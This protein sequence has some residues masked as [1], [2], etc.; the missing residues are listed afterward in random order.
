MAW[1]N[2]P[3]EDYVTCLQTPSQC[4]LVTMWFTKSAKSGPFECIFDE[5][6]FKP[7]A[8]TIQWEF[9]DYSWNSYGIQ[10]KGSQD[11]TNFLRSAGITKGCKNL[12]L[13]T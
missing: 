1:S 10:I 3:L 2:R 8:R 6:R 9:Q 13:H 7:M 5:V 12:V 4:T 11:T